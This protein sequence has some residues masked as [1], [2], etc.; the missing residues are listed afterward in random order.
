MSSPRPAE[1]L[2][3]GDEVALLPPVSGG[4]ATRPKSPTP[5]GIFSRSPATPI[6]SRAAEDRLLQ[7]IDG[8][9]CNLPGRGP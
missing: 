7:G 8:A 6:D 1:P 4:A 5:R 3:D 9:H 2:A